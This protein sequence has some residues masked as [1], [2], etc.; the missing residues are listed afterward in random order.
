MV[1]S[2]SVISDMTS[3]FLL[4]EIAHKEYLKLLKAASTSD[5]VPPPFDFRDAR[6]FGRQDKFYV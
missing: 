4:S 2:S 3:T 5:S 1:S 6:F